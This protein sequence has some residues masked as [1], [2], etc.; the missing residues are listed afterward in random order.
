MR[1]LGEVLN[2]SRFSQKELKIAISLGVLSWHFVKVIYD[3]RIMVLCVFAATQEL[4][5]KWGLVPP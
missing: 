2:I 5:W 1:N 3:W 4:L